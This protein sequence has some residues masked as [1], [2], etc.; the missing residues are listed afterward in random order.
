MKPPGQDRTPLFSMKHHH[1]A[2]GAT[3]E[4]V[5]SHWEGFCSGAGPVRAWKMSDL[6]LEV[7]R[8]L[9]RSCTVI[10]VHRWI[11]HARFT[12]ELNPPLPKKGG[13]E[14]SVRGED[15]FEGARRPH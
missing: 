3:A 14:L 1:G 13:R 12:V 15:V 9:Y 11:D 2:V 7:A 4:W 6:A 5:S 10:W 8:A